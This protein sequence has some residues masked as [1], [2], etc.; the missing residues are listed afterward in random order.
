MKGASPSATRSEK[1][2]R[3]CD[4]ELN[5]PCEFRYLAVHDSCHWNR[6]DNG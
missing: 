5:F 3:L 6:P 4:V 1:D 2:L